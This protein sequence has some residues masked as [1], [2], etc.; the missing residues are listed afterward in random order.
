MHSLLPR[1]DGGGEPHN[2]SKIN[3]NLYGIH[4]PLTSYLQ[5]QAKSARHKKIT[6]KKSYYENTEKISN[7]RII[8]DRQL[9]HGS[10]HRGD[11][12]NDHRF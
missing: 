12:R 11:P 5:K 10:K 1:G 2:T 6:I 8:N 3:F 9:H 4:S 7:R